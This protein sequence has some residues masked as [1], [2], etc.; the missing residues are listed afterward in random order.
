MDEN[1][2]RTSGRMRGSS[3]I[4]TIGMS[5][6]AQ[7]AIAPGVQ[8]RERLYTFS[9]RQ[10][11]LL[12]ALALLLGLAGAIAGG[13]Y[14]HHN[15]QHWAAAQFEQRQDAINQQLIQAINQLASRPGPPAPQ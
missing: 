14:L 2:E 1:D 13:M 4:P 9:L 11:L 6:F 5:G 3:A 12:G 10:M 15:A 8:D 7:A